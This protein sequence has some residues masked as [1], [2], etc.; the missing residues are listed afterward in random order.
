MGKN[1]GVREVKEERRTKVPQKA[2]R[3]TLQDKEEGR[4]YRQFLS[5]LKP[6]TIL[7]E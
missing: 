3:S 2:A 1:Y 7:S 4:L 6:Q 5:S